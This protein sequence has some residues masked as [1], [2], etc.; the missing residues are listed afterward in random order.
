MYIFV[1]KNMCYCVQA[2]CNYSR[3]IGWKRNNDSDGRTH[4]AGEFRIIV[5]RTMKRSDKI[6]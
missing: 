2:N 1:I 6:I 4:K 3:G 5:D